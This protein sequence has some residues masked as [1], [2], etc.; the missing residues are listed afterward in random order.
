M[1]LIVLQ[2]I[3]KIWVAV[4]NKETHKGIA[5][6]EKKFEFYEVGKELKLNIWYRLY[7]EVDYSKRRFIS[8]TIDG[9]GI[10]KTINL[11]NHRLDYPRVRTH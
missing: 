7:S 4:G 9:G 11:S 2:R 5:S 3:G 8:F 1:G 6:K 10:N